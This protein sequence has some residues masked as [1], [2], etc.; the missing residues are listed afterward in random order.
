MTARL[1]R[2]AACQHSSDKKCAHSGHCYFGKV[3]VGKKCQPKID[4]FGGA[5]DRIFKYLSI[6]AQ[7]DKYYS[8]K[9]IK[10]CFVASREF[11]GWC[12]LSRK[13]SFDSFAAIFTVI[14]F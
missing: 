7:L 6:N 5:G 2:T 10:L 11:N 14:C 4:L 9:P 13:Y 1:H 8:S 3:L 12:G